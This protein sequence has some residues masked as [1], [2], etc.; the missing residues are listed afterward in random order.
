MIISIGHKISLES[1]LKV[2]KKVT[3]FRVPQ[4]IRLADK[5]SRELI[6]IVEK[7][8]SKYPVSLNNSYITLDYDALIQP[9]VKDQSQ[10]DSDN[11]DD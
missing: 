7:D 11:S 5:R 9:K 1:S 4:P 6:A 8:K 2:V 3:K 10:N